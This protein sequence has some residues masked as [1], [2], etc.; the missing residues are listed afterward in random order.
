VLALILDSLVQAPASIRTAAPATSA[1]R[2]GCTMVGLAGQ[3]TLT[4]GGRPPGWIRS[5]RILSPD[6]LI[7]PSAKVV[8]G[9]DGVTADSL[10]VEG[11]FRSFHL[12]AGPSIW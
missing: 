3:V 9:D 7:W 4:V 12:L 8:M 2:L 10:S 5:T 1:K 6:G 11:P